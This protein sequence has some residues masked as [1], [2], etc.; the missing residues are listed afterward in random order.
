MSSTKFDFSPGSKNWIAKFFELLD[1]GAL[2]IDEDLIHQK[3]ANL[4]HF[5]SHQTGL[6]YGTVKSF[7]FS[8]ALEK[9]RFNTDEQLQLLLFETLLFTYMRK[10]QK[11]V[12][13]SDFTA[14]L[15]DFYKGFEGAGLLDQIKFK[16]TAQ[17]NRKLEI[18]LASRVG[19]KSSFLGANYWL[20]HLSNAFIFLDV[21]LFRAY[22]EGDH[23]P[24]LE[25]YQRYTSSVL[26]GLIYVAHING[27]VDEK[28]K[29]IL[30]LFI[31]SAALP[32]SLQKTYKERSKIGITLKL[33]QQ[34]WV[35]D[36]LLAQITYEFGHLLLQSTHV[37]QAEE[38]QKL[39]ALGEALQMNA[40]QMELSEEMCLAFIAQSGPNELLV[41]KQSTEASFAF[42]ETSKRWLRI[43]GRNRE[44]LLTEMRESKELMALLQKS[45]K[46]E[47][48]L[49]EKEQVKDQFYDILKSM[50]SLALFLL[51]GGTL[52]LPIVMKLVPELIPSAFK[53]N[54]VEKKQPEDEL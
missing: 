38:R 51:P 21:I 14:V 28:E 24:F 16:T 2:S 29:K 12:K 53:V 23:S 3:E 44:R 8:N 33:L 47:L 17:A 11:P 15:L 36:H 52:L 45:T 20:K 5:I 7:I 25:K 32:H 19:I 30:Q 1:Q 18:L 39:V 22:L 41:Y 9:R 37:I 34:E 26:N 35:P 46:E 27:K 10:Q 40:A 42:K 31:A 48:S 50:P 6:I 49:E 13:A 43:I 4:T 54:E